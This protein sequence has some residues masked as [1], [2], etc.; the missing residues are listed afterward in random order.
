MVEL[1]QEI[2][3]LLSF[4]L[5]VTA[6][7]IQGQAYFN[8]AIK[9][10]GVQSLIIGTISLVYYL[11][12]DN[13]EFIILAGIIFFTRVFLTPYILLRTVKYRE[14]DREKVKVLSSFVLNLTF[15]FSAT[16]L[17]AYAVFTRAIPTEYEQVIMPMTLFFQGLFLIA[18]RKSTVA[19]ILG[20]IELENSLVMLGIFLI[21][22]PILIDATV[23]LDVL[24][25]VV[26]S[27]I[28]IVEKR[29]HEPLEEL[30]G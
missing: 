25:L 3:L 20:Y 21:P 5:P 4:L 15:F 8:P 22:P 1:I 12:T 11:F 29:D 24:A 10:V 18:S 26:I 7:Y 30:T 23:F 2:I 27:S 6:L 17:V 28:I 13:I 16:L 19:H 14:W 9:V